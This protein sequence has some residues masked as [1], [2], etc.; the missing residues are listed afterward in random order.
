MLAFAPLLLAAPAFGQTPDVAVVDAIFQQYRESIVVSADG[1]ETHETTASIKVNTEAGVQQRGTLSIPYERDT[2]AL[3]VRYV[4]VRKAGGTVVDTPVETA[5]DQP[6]DITRAAPAFTDTY[7]RHINV[8]GVSIGDT[9]EFA[10]RLE[11]RPIFNGYLAEEDEWLIGEAVEDGEVTLTTPSS[12]PLSVKTHG[13]QPVV[14]TAGN[15]RVYRWTIRHPSAWT[16]KDIQALVR[17]RK[18]RRPAVELTSFR[19]WDEVGGAVRALWRGRAEITPEIRAKAEALAK[20]RPT[21]AE[22]IA[23]IYD[24]VANDVRYVEIAFGV[25][26][27]QPH[28]ANDVLTNGFGD[29]KDKHVLLEAMLSAIGI[30]ASP[31]LVAPGEAI[32]ADVPSPVQFTHVVTLAQ[33]K[34]GPLWLDAT[35]PHAWPGYLLPQER[36]RQALGVPAVDAAAL[37]RTIADPPQPTVSRFVANG[38]LGADG[39]LTAHIEETY[40]GDLAYIVRLVWLNV[41]KERGD[42]AARAMLKA[43]GMSGDISERTMPD[44]EDPTKPFRAIYT[45]T[46]KNYWASGVAA[47][48]PTMSDLPEATA[49]APVDTEAA[50]RMESTSTI[51]L[52]AGYDPSFV[53]QPPLDKSDKRDFGS[54]TYHLTLDGM[55]FVAT[56]TFEITGVDVPAD[57]IDEYTALRTTATASLPV[58]TLREAWPW[59]SSSTPRFERRA[60]KNPAATQLVTQAQRSSPLLAIDLLQRAVALEPDHPSA[61]V[62]LGQMLLYVG[63]TADAD[64]AWQ[65]ASSVAP[66]P[67]VYKV[68]GMALANRHDWPGAEQA[69]RDGVEKYPADRDMPALL[70]ETLLNAGQPAEAAVVLQAEAARR[71][72]SSRLRS[73]LGRAWLRSGRIDDGVAA[74]HESVVLEPVP[75]M[76]AVAASE[77]ADVGRDLDRARDYAEKAIAQTLTENATAEFARLPPNSSTATARLAFYYETLGRV[78]LKSKDDDRAEAYCRTSWELAFRW[79][80]AQCLGDIAAARKDTAAVDRYRAFVRTAPPMAM[81]TGLF[82]AGPDIKVI[83]P[84]PPAEAKANYAASIA[85][86]ALQQFPLEQPAGAR[87]TRPVDLLT[88]SDGRIREVRLSNGPGEFDP[89]VAQLLNLKVGPVLPDH[90]QAVLLRHALIRCPDPSA[91]KPVVTT[92]VQGATGDAPI[93]AQRADQLN[94]AAKADAVEGCRLMMQ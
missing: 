68:K 88:G 32:D 43:A 13:V 9:I 30:H 56:R 62:F 7:E 60:G 94:A 35:L 28:A 10:Y 93:A 27:Y 11:Q 52:P 50:V 45:L 69:F 37:L 41:P 61:W 83:I 70:G 90:A 58:L 71:P 19:T 75:D 79:K 74:M 21:D 48:L 66:S 51:E 59:T 14:T 76:W 16:L 92:T 81:P 80:S 65:K 46:T 2:S 20:D 25:G 85:R 47:L 84:T 54:Y 38:R 55:R 39:T 29:C 1:T 17:E 24:F 23:A 33:T 36:N 53:N 91:P 77:L 78:L 67:D 34:D 6:T 3:E 86:D 5:I 8:R 87:G 64:A 73:S 42:E 40:S 89:I 4:R 26:R 22:K 63:R 18:T 15:Q 31:V 57:R 44:L 12:M 82:D 72:R 49:G